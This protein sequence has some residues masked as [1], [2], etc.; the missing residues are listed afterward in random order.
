MKR[1]NVSPVRAL[2]KDDFIESER[3]HFRERQPIGGMTTLRATPPPPPPP[4]R[5]AKNE[6]EYET[7][8]LKLTSNVMSSWESYPT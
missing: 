4:P 3:D 1:E 2:L 8:T 5:E 6:T 7:K